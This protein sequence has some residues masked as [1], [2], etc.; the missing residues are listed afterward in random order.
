MEAHMGKRSSKRSPEMHMGQPSLKVSKSPTFPE[1]MSAEQ[2]IAGKQQFDALADIQAELFS[3]LTHANLRWM[4]TIKKRDHLASAFTDK[5]TAARSFAETVSACQ[6][7][8]RRRM[9][10]AEE[11]AQQL[12]AD[13]EAFMDTAARLFLKSNGRNEP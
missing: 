13:S 4:G 8:V 9:E 1:S 5:L 6:E 10:I 12:C 3:K 11:D 7:W 2:Q